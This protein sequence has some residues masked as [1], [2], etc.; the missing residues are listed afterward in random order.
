MQ[1]DTV[2]ESTTKVLEREAA[3]AQAGTIEPANGPAA[4]VAQQPDGADLP[5]LDAPL[6]DILDELLLRANTGDARAACR[7]AAEAEHC[8]AYLGGQALDAIDEGFVRAVSE[9]G[10]VGHELDVAVRSHAQRAERIR[11]ERE[12]CAGVPRERISPLAPHYL[13]AAQ[14]G[15]P[16]AAARYVLFAEADDPAFLIARPDLAETYRRTAFS[17][18]QSQLQAGNSL[19]A[20]IWRS[21]TEARS[22]RALNAVLPPEWKDPELAYALADL[23]EGVPR[24]DGH[25]ERMARIPEDT[26]LEAR[27]LHLRWFT[28]GIADRTREIL[29]HGFDQRTRCDR[30]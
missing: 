26:R 15:D 24:L 30:L 12:R 20:A 16:L 29:D 27:R 7:V 6:R 14:L 5:P 23:I 19:M 3:S 10:L 21:A 25:E 8:I 17:I 1:G 2:A 13:R 18:F 11:R 9:S 28:G 22:R 4:T